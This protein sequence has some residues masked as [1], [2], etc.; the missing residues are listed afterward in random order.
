MLAVVI[1]RA[2]IA[3]LAIAAAVGLAG[4]TAQS[5]KDSAEDF[6]GEERRVAEVIED[7]QDAARK[8]DGDEVCKTLLAESLV[9]SITQA[10]GEACAE[11]M[12][13]ALGDVDATELQV[14]KISIQGQDATATVRG[15]AGDDERTDTMTLRRQGR[16]WR[17]AGL[18]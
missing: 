12:D 11:A 9:R 2:P 7:L 18:R 14:E 13:D 4:C 3:V 6:Q 1:A 16:Q 17:I 5:S 8:R 15:E 10:S